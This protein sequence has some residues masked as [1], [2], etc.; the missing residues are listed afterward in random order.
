MVT[1]TVLILFC[2]YF[3]ETNRKTDDPEQKEK[4]EIVK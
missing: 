2:L 4:G 1:F 3:S